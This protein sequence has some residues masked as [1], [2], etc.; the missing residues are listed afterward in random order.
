MSGIILFIFG[1]KSY[2][3]LSYGEHNPSSFGKSITL[4]NRIIWVMADRDANKNFIAI[5]I[6]MVTFS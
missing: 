4:K 3:I 5:C 6:Q 2:L 1:R